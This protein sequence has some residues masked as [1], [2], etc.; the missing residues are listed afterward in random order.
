MSGRLMGPVLAAALAF[1]ACG[2]ALGADLP[3]PQP[4]AAVPA[5]SGW[6]Y[7]MTPYGWLTSLNGSQTVRGRTVDVNASFPRV[8]EATAGSGGTLVGLMLDL[9]A[10]NGPVSLLAD[11]VWTD[12]GIRRRGERTVTPEP[13]VVGTVGAAAEARLQM[14]IVEAGAAYEVARFGAVSLDA[15]AGARY[16]NQQGKLSFDLAG[17]VDLGDVV[18]ARGLAIAK[19]GSFSWLDGF[20]GGRARIA[21]APGQE[22][23][24]RGDIGGGGSKG[25]WQALAAYSIEFANRNGVSY[26]GVL[27]YRA[28]YVDYA[29]G[30]GRRRYEFD[31]LQH[32]P[33]VGLNIRF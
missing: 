13:G 4:P 31:M 28:L 22:I 17:T 19:S 10:R 18:V 14:G 11:V 33:V 12:L 16:W 5:L 7:R 32:G 2:G 20:I 27:G 8:V 29:S 25:S 3:A 15:L 21:V 30:E 26:S 24:L 9:E 6:T 1:T 23:Q